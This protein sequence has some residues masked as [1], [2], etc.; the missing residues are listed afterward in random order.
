V[1]RRTFAIVSAVIVGAMLLLSAWAWLQLPDG[2]Q[3]PIHWGVD[4]EADGFASKTVGL[5]LMPLVTA[6]VA[7]LLWI[8]PVIEPRRANIEKSGKAYSAIAYGTM[9]LLV[10]IDVLV[11]AAAL[12]AT[13]D[14]S[15]LIFVGVGALFIVI[16]NYLPK[17]RSTYLVGI[18]TPWT[19]T[20]E[21][22]WDRTHRLGGRLFVL[23]GIVMIGLGLLRPAPGV[24]TGVLIAW[25]VILLVVLFAY[26]YKVWKSD[27]ARW[28]T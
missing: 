17:V 6:G 5:L 16:G 24:L 10:A 19:L 9:L 7:G 1:N 27:P 14:I 4:G 26:S 18:R 21:L 22:S 2:A 11:T 28:D 25:V 3:I 8:I 12:G 23:G 20:S 15:L 13:F